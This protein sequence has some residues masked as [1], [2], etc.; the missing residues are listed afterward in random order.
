ME[1]CIRLVYFITIKPISKVQID[2]EQSIDKV[3]FEI[4]YV[5]FI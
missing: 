3:R 5:D 1:W 4:L 2:N